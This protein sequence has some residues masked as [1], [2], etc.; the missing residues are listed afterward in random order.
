MLSVEVEFKLWLAI[1][2]KI[3]ADLFSN[4]LCNQLMILAKNTENLVLSRNVC[5]SG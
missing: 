3:D 5:K 4:A 1:E 2:D